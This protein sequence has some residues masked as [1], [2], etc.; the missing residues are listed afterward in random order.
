MGQIKGYFCYDY[1]WVSKFQLFASSTQD[2]Y[3]E[4]NEYARPDKNYNLPKGI[5]VTGETKQLQDDVVHQAIKEAENNQAQEYDN[6]DSSHFISPTAKQ[7]RGKIKTT[8]VILGGIM[9]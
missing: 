5:R 8:R 4:L 6:N 2:S 9:F 3:D 7:P 1:L